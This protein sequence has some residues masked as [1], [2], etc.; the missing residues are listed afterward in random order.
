MKKWVWTFFLLASLFLSGNQ[1]AYG[2][3]WVWIYSNENSSTYIDTSTILK[4]NNNGEAMVWVK[5][6]YTSGTTE[7][8]LL[9]INDRR[10]FTI[11]AIYIYDTKTKHTIRSWTQK[12]QASE[13]WR[14]VLP[15]S[16]G[17]CI[18]SYIFPN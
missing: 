17:E 6:V 16:L 11:Y 8:N 13:H 14:N 10:Q 4:S 7:M 18:Y 12:D 2:A 3:N 15:Y 9:K 1:N 5:N